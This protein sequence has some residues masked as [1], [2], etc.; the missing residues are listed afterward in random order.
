MTEMEYDVKE[1]NEILQGKKPF[2][3]K[4]HYD[5]FISYCTAEGAT[6]KIFLENYCGYYLSDGCFC[7][8]DQWA[9]SSLEEILKHGQEIADEKKHSPDIDID[10][11]ISDVEWKIRKDYTYEFG[12]KKAMYIHDFKINGKH[13]KYVERNIADFGVTINPD[14]ETAEGGLVIKNKDDH[15]KLWFKDFIDN[16]WKFIRPLSEEERTCYL[17]VK[18]RGKFSMC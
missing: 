6:R 10:K 11:A 14:F 7:I 12:Q 3:I 4:R 8:P 15:N 17:I 1:Y 9:N 2:N 16:T 5:E 18:K 13:I